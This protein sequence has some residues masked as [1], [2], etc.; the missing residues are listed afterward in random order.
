MTV[1]GMFNEEREIVQTLDRM[2]ENERIL[3]RELA[4]AEHRLDLVQKEIARREAELE[5]L[6]EWKKG[7]NE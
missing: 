2:R 5:D 6:R 4:E 7:S 3:E 1:K